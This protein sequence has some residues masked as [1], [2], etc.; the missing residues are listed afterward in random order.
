[1][2]NRK[3][4]RQQKDPQER[5]SE[6]IHTAI[7]F[8]SKFGFENTDVQT[9]ADSIGIAKGTIYLYFRTK[10]ELFHEAVDFAICQLEKQIDTEVNKAENSIDKLKAVVSAYFKFFEKHK[11]LANII[12]HE[13]SRDIGYAQ[14]AYLKVYSRNS[15]YLEAIFNLGIEEKVFR[16]LD[17][18]KSA[19]SLANLLHGTLYTFAY[20]RAEMNTDDEI[21]LVIDLILNGIARRD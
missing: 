3:R 1:M 18:S 12:V 8:F 16:K 13:Q 21:Q 9:I 15:K 11:S 10:E 6:I 20:S 4:K 2:I 7:D 14:T 19:H 5:K 17:I